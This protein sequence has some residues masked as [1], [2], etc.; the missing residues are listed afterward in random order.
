MFVVVDFG[1]M[2]GLVL[3][4]LF[5]FYKNAVSILYLT[6][7]T[8][9]RVLRTL[10]QAIETDPNHILRALQLYAEHVEEKKARKAARKVEKQR[11]KERL[12]RDVR[13]REMMRGGSGSG[14]SLSLRERSVSEQ[15][16]ERKHRPRERVHRGK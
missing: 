5:A 16:L 15:S 8:F 11:E 3:N 12:E 6:D 10:G 2:T 14:S 7:S 13:E 9:S 1:L 4:Q